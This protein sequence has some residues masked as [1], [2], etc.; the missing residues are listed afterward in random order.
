MAVHTITMEVVRGIISTN[1][2]GLFVNSPGGDIN[3]ALCLL[4]FCRRQ[5]IH[6]T[7]GGECSSAACYLLALPVKQIDILRFSYGMQ[8]QP[9]ILVGQGDLSDSY[10]GKSLSALAQWETDRPIYERVTGRRF[11]GHYPLPLDYHDLRRLNRD[12]GLAEAYAFVE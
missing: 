8:H 5:H 1:P 7:I 11:D 9:K 10:D 4:S 2:D 6:V 12:Q 3:A